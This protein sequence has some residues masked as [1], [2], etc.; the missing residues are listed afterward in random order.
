MESISKEWISEIAVRSPLTCDAAPVPYLCRKCYGWNAVGRII[1]I[2]EAVGILAAQ[3]LGE[4]G[5]QLTLRTFH[6]GGIYSEKMGDFKL[7]SPFDG[8]V[9]IPN[10]CTIKK[11]FTT[12]EKISTFIT[13]RNFTSLSFHEGQRPLKNYF[14]KTRHRPIHVV[15]SEDTLD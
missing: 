9:V 4:P 1:D 11:Y 13:C 12:K 3:S 15:Y 6:T 14:N 5:T 2:G 7:I 10:Y 8:N